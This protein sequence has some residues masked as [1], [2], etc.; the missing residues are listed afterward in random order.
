MKLQSRRKQ[1]LNAGQFIVLTNIIIHKFYI[2]QLY[3]CLWTIFQLNFF[4][5]WAP[6]P[7]RCIWWYDKKCHFAYLISSSGCLTD[8]YLWT[9]LILIQRLGMAATC[10][11]CLNLTC[12][13][14]N[15]KSAK[16]SFISRKHCPIH[17][18]VLPNHCL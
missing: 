3:P 11:L 18:K 12:F 14:Y 1:F 13:T 8:H 4:C 6:R 9:D 7:C 17:V 2:F 15:N 10:W 16:S 5:A